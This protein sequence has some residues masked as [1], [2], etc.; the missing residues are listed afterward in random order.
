MS[1]GPSRREVMSLA[2]AAALATVP[3]A[4]TASAQGPAP[5]P[6]NYGPAK[7]FSWG[8][9]V[10]RAREAAARPYKPVPLPMP[11]VVEAIDY[12]QHGKIR[13]RADR[14]LYLDSPFV[15]PVAFF[16]V[17]RLFK[18]PVHMYAVDNGKAREILYSPALFD[19]PADSP[20]QQ[21]PADV[22]FAGFQV[23]EIK[24]RP[25]WKTQDWVA[26]LGASYFRAIGAL[27]QYGLSARGIAID[28]AAPTPEEFPDFTEFY[29]Q[30]AANASNPIVV[31]AF[32]D[33]PSVT[34]AY[35]FSLKRT[36]GVVMDVEASLFMR[37]DV[38]RFGIAPL[39]SMYWYGEQ[40]KPREV[41]WRPE[42][43]D[44]DGLSI[45][46]GAGE[47]IWRPLNN[48]GRVKTNAFVDNN[49]RGFGLM[50]R[51]R[52]NENYLDGVNY[53][54]RPSLWVEPI[55]AWG[56]GSV[57]L[58]EIPTDDEIHDNIVAMWV[59]KQPV[60]A[61][62]A[63][64]VRYRLHW[65]A[66]EPFPPA[67]LARVAGTR[68][69]RGGEPGKP[70]PAGVRKF[71]V[72]FVGTALSDLPEGA[73]L[74]PVINVSRGQTSLV[75][76]ERVPWTDRWRVQFDL[77]AD[78]ADPVDMSLFVEVGDKRLTETWLYQFLPRQMA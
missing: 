39:T 57:Q 5:G 38:H 1:S 77:A 3:G 56:E 41:D 29:F 55:G 16:P 62:Q 70:R 31:H 35:R 69:G 43:H 18:K 51:D 58:V 78:G 74:E 10:A 66:D 52:N 6:I 61:G 21:L 13:Y 15:Y 64:E 54:R 19:M 4:R 45:W 12:E 34:G 73:K 8:E 11:E 60:R 67:D 59:P 46:T 44:S 76:V 40:D 17:G 20:A 47:R 14:T 27:G 22:G 63:H 53:E 48:P 50:Q 9:L 72:D 24:S 42:V 36:E 26:F 65:L 68:I 2:F 33:G 28:V 25:D 23:K 75:I 32:L 49:P 37:Q 7:S 71:V 30:G